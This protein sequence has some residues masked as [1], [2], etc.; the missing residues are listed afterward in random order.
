MAP[1][2]IWNGAVAFGAVNVPIKVYGALEDKAIRFRELHVKDGSEVGHR[3]I[4]Q[5][6]KEIPRD[7][8]VKGF[9]V[10]GGEYVVLSDDE[11][12]AADQ[13]A[14]KAIELEDFVPGEDIDPVFYGKPYHLAPQKDAEDAY[15]LLVKALEKSGRVGIG[16]V[17]LRQREQLVSV[18]PV[19]G[20]LRMQ[21]MR[22][23][24][25]LVDPDSLDVDEPSKKPGKREIDMAGMLV[26]TLAATFEP[27][28]Y[29]D[30]YRERVLEVVKAKEKGEQITLPDPEPAS[31]S[32]DLM[33]ALEASLKA[34]K[35]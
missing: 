20:V 19:D 29:E 25:E 5:K 14:R 6:G 1:R 13:P 4:D 30:T 23:A 24:D 31:D 18:R 7:R 28:R 10:S 8:V 35:G 11:I 33:A 17:S 9:E 3:L 26:E 16:R 2:S 15:A 12:K 32:D 34:S 27:E 21:I 22:F